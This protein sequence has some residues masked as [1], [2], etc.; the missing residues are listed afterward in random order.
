M[1]QTASI[2][3]EFFKVRTAWETVDPLKSWRLAI[4]RLAYAD[5]DIV[6]KFMETE[7][8]AVG[9]FEDIFFR[10]DSPFN[11]NNLDFEK[12][13]W[14][15]FEDWFVRPQDERQDM[16]LALQNDGLLLQEFVPN[17]TLAPGFNNLCA[18]ILRFK[19]CIKGM[20]QTNFCLYFPPQRTDL[21]GAGR[22]FNKVLKTGV[23][24]G[25]RLAT[26]DFLENQK[27][28]ID[29]NLDPILVVEMTPE[30][31]MMEA[32]ENEMD[33][34]G[35]TFDTVGIDAQFRKQI[36]VVMNE[37]TKAKTG[38]LNKEVNTL[39]SLGKQMNSNSAVVSSLLVAAQAYF[40]VNDKEKCERFADEAVE[41]SAKDMAKNDP[42]GYPTWKAGMML[43]GALLVTNRKRK[44]AADHYEQ[45]A[46]TGLQQGD[47]F[48][49]M[50]GY[51]LS[52]HMH[53]E[54][55]EL[56]TA[57]EN[58]LLAL[59]AGSYMPIDQ[60][61][62]STFVHAAWLAMHI[63]KQIKERS[64][65]HI[66]EN[67]LAAWLGDDWQELMQQEGMEKAKVKGK[68]SLFG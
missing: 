17:K 25:I 66:L 30:L 63:G 44:Q 28:N 26:I 55:K 31:N 14:Q 58:L 47:S 34:A 7:R 50:E 1:T 6:D 39:L 35:N 19:A 15:E 54:R 60:R 62:Q 68:K 36:R 65:M 52:G 67:Q 8:T 45:M 9:V 12:A 27:I 13:L 10:F 38:M 24:K 59:A 57:F 21:P 29:R 2:A 42:A 61:R 41:R 18:E 46:Q 37:T 48:F 43:K 3:Q 32:I 5:V 33:K 20:E 23:P 11:G 64:D 51:R 16:L 49:V 56:N 22:W 40:S 4:W 53:Y